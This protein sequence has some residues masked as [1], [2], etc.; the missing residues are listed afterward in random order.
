M[1]VYTKTLIALIVGTLIG[2]GGVLLLL[3]DKPAV[4]VADIQVDGDG[5]RDEIAFLRKELA[6]LKQRA[7]ALAQTENAH[8]SHQVR[9]SQDSSA[10]D[11]QHASSESAD[12]EAVRWRVSAIE[13][14]VPLDDQQRERLQRKFAGDAVGESDG[15]GSSETL[16]EILG[17]E[18]ARFYTEQVSAAFTRYRQREI[19]SEVLWFSRRLALS[20]EQEQSM[21]D[22]FSG[23][24]Q[25]LQGPSDPSNA[26]DANSATSARQGV[27]EMIAENRSRAELRSQQLKSVLTPEQY[28]NF[29]KAEAESPQR[30]METFHEVD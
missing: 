3:P 8:T 17:E 30:D 28:Q 18:N 19:E 10:S 23:V 11:H 6:N 14:F 7:A 22:V 1:K 15:E 13:K 21:R 16:E 29:L 4:T 24:E 20:S 27:K 25:Q 9:G 5:C 12:D 2:A 26:P